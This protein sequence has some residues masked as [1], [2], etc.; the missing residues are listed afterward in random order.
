MSTFMANKANIERKWYVIDAA[1]KPLGKTAVAAAAAY[2]CGAA[3]FTCAMMVPT[4]I[5]ANQHYADMAPLFANLGICLVGVEKCLFPQPP[6]PPLHKVKGS[7]SDISFIILPLSASLTTVP[8]GTFKM[9]SV[10]VFPWNFDFIPSPP[11]SATNFL[12]YLN[13]NFLPHNLL[14]SCIVQV[15][16]LLY[17]FRSQHR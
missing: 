4:E 1:N 17:I 8:G 2:I 5:L 15:L 11:F 10:A 14:I 13:T 12:L 16:V 3:G 6:L 9:R 7:E